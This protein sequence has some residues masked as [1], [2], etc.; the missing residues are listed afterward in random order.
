MLSTITSMLP[1]S[2]KVRAALATLDIN[3]QE[4][5][6]LDEVVGLIGKNPLISTLVGKEVSNLTDAISAFVDSDMKISETIG[7]KVSALLAIPE[8][9]LNVAKVLIGRLDSSPRRETLYSVLEKVSKA[10]L[11]G[12]GDVK[13]ESATHFVAEGMIPYLSQFIPGQDVQEPVTVHVCPFCK[14]AFCE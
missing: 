12:F 6:A 3:N 11:P 7:S 8:M 1:V 2:A 5:K 4:S 9:R 14:E 13:H 10:P